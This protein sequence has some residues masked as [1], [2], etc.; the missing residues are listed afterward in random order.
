MK[1][2]IMAM[3]IATGMLFGSTLTVCATPKQMPDGGYF[4]ATYY[5]TMN[6]DIYALYGLNEELLYMHYVGCG[7]AEGRLPYDKT[8]DSMTMVN[9]ELIYSDVD[10]MNYTINA[11]IALRNAVNKMGDTKYQTSIEGMTN[12]VN[13]GVDQLSACKDK[14]DVAI[15]M[16]QN[17][18][19]FADVLNY[20]QQTRANIPTTKVIAYDMASLKAHNE[21][22]RK[23]V[24]SYDG[25]YTYTTRMAKTI[26]PSGWAK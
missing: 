21:E 23:F 7:M 16:C 24:V 10:C 20:L 13:S 3:V 18:P 26:S 1:K 5:A 12:C 6:P 22:F 17:N 8:G 9:P 19:K 25:L 14:L 4:D 2:R 11:V 15:G